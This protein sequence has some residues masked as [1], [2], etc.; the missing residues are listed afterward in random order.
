MDEL[1]LKNF[2]ESQQLSVPLI[3]NL[4]KEA[5]FFKDSCKKRNLKNH[6]LLKGKILATLFYEPST[7]TRF[8]FECAMTRLG[9][10]IIGTENAREFS[11]AV[12]G[13]SIEDTIRVVDN[14]S[15]CIVIRHYEEGAAKK[16]A[17]VSSVPIINAGDGR[18]QHPTQSLLDIYTIQNE[19]GRLDNLKIALIGDLANG[20][21]ARS[22]CYLLG[23]FK[24]NNLTFISPTN[25]RMGTD[26]KHYLQMHKTKFN[27]EPDLRKIISDVD[28]IYMTRIQKERMTRK[29]YRKAQGQFILNLDDLILLKK[30][31]RILHPLPKVDEIQLP[32]EVEQEDPRIA[33]F[34]QAE[35]GL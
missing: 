10:S 22:F 27:E 12:K 3:Y 35:N 11:S 29:E 30:E 5:D 1:N 14:Y 33:Y 13:E 26:I 18:G 9:G 32:I 21:T 20:R 28:V 2:Y 4:F 7:R 34:R 25:L 16:A 19:I 6:W 15:D 17:S 24:N 31:A 8:S 23:K